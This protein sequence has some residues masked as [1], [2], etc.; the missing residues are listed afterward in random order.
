MGRR[1]RTKVLA[2]S[3]IEVT[4]SEFRA[5]EDVEVVVERPAALANG[6]SALDIIKSLQGHRLFKSPQEVDQYLARERDSW[7]L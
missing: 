2:G 6:Q 3:K 4:C 5:G 7:D 1:I